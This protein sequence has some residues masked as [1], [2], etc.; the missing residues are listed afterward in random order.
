[1]FLKNAYE[2]KKGEIVPPLPTRRSLM[3]R[4]EE[5]RTSSLGREGEK[6]ASQSR[7]GVDI[8]IKTIT[9]SPSF[10]QQQ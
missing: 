7:R 10:Y 4:R 2:K 9:L 8:L 3:M 1:L 6:R 5:E